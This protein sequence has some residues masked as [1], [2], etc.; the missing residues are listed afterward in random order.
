SVKKDHAA[1][2]QSIQRLRNCA[3]DQIIAVE[4]SSI[5]ALPLAIAR[6]CGDREVPYIVSAGAFR[7]LPDLKPHEKPNSC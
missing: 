2:Y 4:R 7:G 3:A 1:L 5:N 6:S